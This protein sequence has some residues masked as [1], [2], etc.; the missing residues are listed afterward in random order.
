MVIYVLNGSQRV[1]LGLANGSSTRSFTI[2]KYLLIGAG[3]IRFLA[4][5]VGG[6]RTPV[7]EEISVQPGDTVTLTI[8]PQ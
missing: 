6:S 7:S 1:R 3:P 4:D 2:P 5:P 8:P